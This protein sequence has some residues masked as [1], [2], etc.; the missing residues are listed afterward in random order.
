M[1]KREDYKMFLIEGLELK[2]QLISKQEYRLLECGVIIA[3][4][5]FTCTLS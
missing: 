3:N 1:S 4:D 5:E 2:V